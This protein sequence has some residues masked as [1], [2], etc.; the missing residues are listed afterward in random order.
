MAVIGR[1][2]LW[3]ESVTEIIPVSVPG[4]ISNNSLKMNFES[5]GAVAGFRT[6]HLMEIGT[7]I[8]DLFTEIE[9]ELI[10]SSKINV[11][12]ASQGIFMLGVIRAQWTDK[13]TIPDYGFVG[14]IGI[15]P[16]GGNPVIFFLRFNGAGPEPIFSSEFD[17][18]DIGRF[19]LRSN[20]EGSDVVVQLERQS[21][22]TSEWATLER[23][24]FD[25]MPT[26]NGTMGIVG[27]WT[28]YADFGPPDNHVLTAGD[29]GFW[30]DVQVSQNVTDPFPSFP[31]TDGFEDD[32]W[33]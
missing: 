30:D 1:R 4:G 17:L 28:F 2:N 13:T 8:S 9:S 14:G 20:D 25:D 10:W 21:L 23:I 3:D 24:V 11:D 12:P 29:F 26:V 7:A 32:T 19:R 33:E 5:I 22:I 18:D 31:F 15:D 16:A 6:A 27:L